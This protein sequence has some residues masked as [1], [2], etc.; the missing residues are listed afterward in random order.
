MLQNIIYVLEKKYSVLKVS[1]WSQEWDTNITSNVTTACI[2]EEENGSVN[3]LFPSF[4]FGGPNHFWVNA[5]CEYVKS[6]G[7]S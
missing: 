5:T 7:A 4:Q 1:C 3:R 2:C 6:R